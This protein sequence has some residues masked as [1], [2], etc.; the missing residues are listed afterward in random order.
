V[1]TLDGLARLDLL[2]QRYSCRPSDLTGER[3]PYRAYC[4]DEACAIVGSKRDADARAAIEE[5]PGG[6]P[7]DPRQG[8]VVET[9]HGI[10]VVQ[11][12]VPFIGER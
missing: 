9:R 5:T 6:R 3:D 1:W 11:G 7:A 2:A 12:T 4:L 10:P 8:A